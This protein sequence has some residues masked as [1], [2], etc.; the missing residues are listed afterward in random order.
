MNIKIPKTFKRYT[1]ETIDELIK[2]GYFDNVEEIDNKSYM[3]RDINEKFITKESN[4][5]G[6]KLQNNL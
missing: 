4:W 3:L 1:S 5:L 2:L 6:K